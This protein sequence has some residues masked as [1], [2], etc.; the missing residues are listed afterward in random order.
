MSGSVSIELE[1]VFIE[2]VFVL[3]LLGLV[4]E[5]KFTFVLSVDLISLMIFSFKI[6]D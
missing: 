4:C 1:V 5:F 6:H 3:L 2:D